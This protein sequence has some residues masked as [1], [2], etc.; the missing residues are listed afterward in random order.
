MSVFRRNFV[1]LLQEQKTRASTLKAGAR[2]KENGREGDMCSRTA[3]REA[4]GISQSQ[5]SMTQSE[6]HKTEGEL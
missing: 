2:L 4:E 1:F 3:N 6:E 5:Q